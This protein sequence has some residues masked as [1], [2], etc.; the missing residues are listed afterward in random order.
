MTSDPLGSPGASAED[1]DAWLERAVAEE[2]EAF[3]LAL[4]AERNLA[5]GRGRS[6]RRPRSS[7]SRIA[8]VDPEEELNLQTL[9]LRDRQ[10]TMRLRLFL[11]WFAIAAVSVQLI[12]ANLLF[13]NYLA[14]PEW[15]LGTPTEVVVAWLSATVVETI[16]IVVIIARNLFPANLKGI[17]RRDLKKLLRKL[18]D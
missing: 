7:T 14:R 5:S 2:Q 4:E 1:E 3:R 16:G 6:R 12:A 9:K 8:V 10:Q 17:G 15:R 18:E 11:A 13:W